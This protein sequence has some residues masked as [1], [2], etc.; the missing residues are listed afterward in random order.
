VEDNIEKAL[1]QAKESYTKQIKHY[2]YALVDLFF[3]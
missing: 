3:S 1:E 2:L